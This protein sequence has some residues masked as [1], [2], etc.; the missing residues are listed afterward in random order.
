MGTDYQMSNVLKTSLKGIAPCL[1]DWLPFGTT[2]L[3]RPL[4]DLVTWI[5]RE[6]GIVSEDIR[7]KFQA[8]LYN[9]DG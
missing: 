2:L 4:R 3:L 8:V 7:H 6:P 1:A 9:F 5:A